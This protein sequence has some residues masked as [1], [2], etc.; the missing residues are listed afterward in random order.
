M[1]VS[2]HTVKNFIPRNYFRFHKIYSVKILRLPGIGDGAE[3]LPNE[4]TPRPRDSDEPANTWQ[5]KVT[6]LV[7]S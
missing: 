2:G 1:G 6:H 4:R 3:Q 5:L 7:K